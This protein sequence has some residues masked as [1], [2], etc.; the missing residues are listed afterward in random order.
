MQQL[1]TDSKAQLTDTLIMHFL[2]EMLDLTLQAWRALYRYLPYGIRKSGVSD[3]DMGSLK[4]V[5][6]G[7]DVKALVSIL[8][9]DWDHETIKYIDDKDN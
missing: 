6:D 5:H 7:I 1:R 8:R 9:D 3:R 4:A 2:L